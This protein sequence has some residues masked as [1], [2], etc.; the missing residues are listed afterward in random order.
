MADLE[1]LEPW[2][3]EL[4]NQLSA[5]QRN[6]LTR[7]IARGLRQRN[8]RRIQSQ[9]APDG[10]RFEPRKTPGRQRKGQIQRGAMFR[11]LRLSRHM[12]IMA[13][14][15]SA[16]VVF[17]GRVGRIADVHHHGLRDTVSG[18]IKY[19]YP[20]RTLLGFSESDIDYVADLVLGN[21]TKT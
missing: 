16:G 7:D 1:R 15:Q 9:I 6:K 13:T 21:L 14:P 19:N 18:K 10:S 8:Q 11:K 17:M 3:N 2:L 12:K 20:E 4:L 5:Q